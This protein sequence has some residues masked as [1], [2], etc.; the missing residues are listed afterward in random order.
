MNSEMVAENENHRNPLQ[1]EPVG[2]K[3]HQNALEKSNMIPI[4]RLSFSN[5]IFVAAR[6]CARAVSEGMCWPSFVNFDVSLSYRLTLNG[7][8]STAQTQHF[9]TTN[10]ASENN[11]LCIWIILEF[12]QSVLVHF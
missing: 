5:A 2:P 10:I 3:M 12:F 8:L 6:C 11:N 9:E 1:S 7:I 4:H